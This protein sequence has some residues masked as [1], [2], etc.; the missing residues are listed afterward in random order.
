MQKQTGCCAFSNACIVP[1][2]RE[3]LA[4]TN[5]EYC[6]LHM[7]MVMQSL[8]QPAPAAAS[9]L[10]NSVFRGPAQAGQGRRSRWSTY[11]GVA[12]MV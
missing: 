12:E 8:V 3:R 10:G 2:P 4:A 6:H 5:R 9:D 11:A 7:Q 1:G